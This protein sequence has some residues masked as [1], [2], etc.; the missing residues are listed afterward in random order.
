MIRRVVVAATAVTLGLAGLV[1]TGAGPAGAAKSPP[2]D[3]VG[4]V[5]CAGPGKVKITPPLSNTA[6]V[7]IR[8]IIG[9]FNLNC[10]NGGAGSPTGNPAVK[11]VTGK[12]TVN[13]PSPASNTCATLL[14]T[15]STSFTADILWKSA[16]GKVN[17]THI[18]WS[19]FNGTATGFD[20][21]GTAGT[22]T[23]TGSYGGENAVAHAGIPA[24]V[25]AGLASACSGS[26]IK[27]I[28][29]SPDSTFDLS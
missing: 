27:K 4:A 6:G 25:L 12:M 8:T 28:N 15:S 22:S 14:G 24:A 3:A 19:N 2:F 9:K 16:G 18:V 1:A 13:A 10:T 29:F 17:P 23:V 11:V 26:G 7:G 5:H 20:L 21:P